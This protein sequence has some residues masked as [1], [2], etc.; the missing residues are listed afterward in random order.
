MNTRLKIL[1]VALGVGLLAIGCGPSPGSTPEATAHAMAKLELKQK[2]KKVERDFEDKQWELNCLEKEVE[3][4]A[5]RG[6]MRRKIENLRAE[7]KFWEDNLSKLKGEGTYDLADIQAADDN[8]KT[9]LIN[10]WGYDVVNVKV[11]ENDP[12]SREDFYLDYRK[13]DGDKIPLT[14][15]GGKWKFKND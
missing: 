2:P 12:G 6:Q 7:V 4:F 5:D 1:G 15:D 13:I 9:V 8:N 3:W 11:S 14:N 10:Y